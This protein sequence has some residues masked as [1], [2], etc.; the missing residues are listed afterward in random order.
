MKTA[1]PKRRAAADADASGASGRLPPIPAHGP[2]FRLERR[3]LGFSDVI[4]LSGVYRLI[5]WGRRVSRLFV[6]TAVRGWNRRASNRRRTATCPAIPGPDVAGGPLI[7]VLIPVFKPPERW[8]RA[9]LDSL[10]DQSYPNWEA[11]LVDDD[12]PDPWVRAVLEEYRARDVRFRIDYRRENGGI[13]RAT[14]Q[15][16]AMA[17][18]PFVALLDQDDS[19]TPDALRE[20]AHVIVATPDVDLVYSDEDKMAADGRLYDATYKPGWSPELLLGTMYVGHLSCYRTAAVVEVGGFRPAFDGAQDYDL[21]LRVTALGGK[22]HHI[23]KVLYHWTALAGSTAR[24]LSSKFYAIARQKVALEEHLGRTAATPGRV[25]PCRSAGY[26]RVVF[27]PPNPAPKVSIV[28]P[29]AGRTAWVAGRR[30]NLLVNC[31]DSVRK[32]N[33]YP[34]LEFVVIHNND[35]DKPTLSALQDVPDL[36]LVAYSYEVF[37]F[38][39]KLNVGVA[40][41]VGDYVLLMN[42]DVQVI[43][44]AFI[45]DLLGLSA[46]PGVGAVGPKLLFADGNIQH[47]GIT[48]SHGAPVHTLIGEPRA[49]VGPQHIASLTHNAVAATGAC[50]MVRRDLYLAVGG[51]NE[52]LPSNYNDVDFCLK[53]RD[54][55]LRIAIDPSIELYHFESLSKS[56][57]F[58]WELQLFVHRRG[59]LRDPY[60]NPNFRHSVFYRAGDEAQPVSVTTQIL[61]RIDVHRHRAVPETLR[62]S[63]ILGVYMAPIRL[64]D[65]LADTIIRQFYPHFEWLIVSDGDGRPELQAWLT[66]MER[67]DCR[68]KVISRP[69]NGGIMASYRTAFLAATGDYVVPVDQ[70][71]FLPL[72]ALEECAAFLEATGRPAAAYSDE[73]K[74]DMRSRQ[75]WPFHKP[76]LDTLL[77]TNM[78]YTAHLCAIRRDAALAHGLYQDHEATWCHDWDSF[79]RLL[80]AGERIE[81]LPELLYAWRINP[82]STAS[83]ATSGKPEAHRSHRHVLDQHLRLSGLADRLTVE[84]NPLYGHPG[85]WRLRPTGARLPPVRL[86]VMPSDDRNATLSRYAGLDLE[87]YAGGATLTL[88]DGPFASAMAAALVG[89]SPDTLIGVVDLDAEPLSPDWL[90]EMAGLIAPF[91]EAAAV[92]GRFSSRD[93]KILWRGGY[94]GFAGHIGSPDTGRDVRHSGYHGI[95]FAQHKVDVVAATGWLAR[96]DVLVEVERASQ[97]LE[98]ADP[99]DWATALALT[100]SR[101]GRD[102]LY[103]PFAHWRTGRRPPMPSMP[104]AAL[105]AALGIDWPNRSRYYAGRLSVSPAEAWQPTA[106]RLH[107]FD[108]AN[109]TF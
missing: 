52:E 46:Q 105:L 36:R 77:L 31:I 59:L 27:A 1:I 74:S 58:P 15:A 79:T 23:P 42:D 108:R 30:V 44:P 82:G 68:I 29:T 80:R 65:E 94:F 51:F 56:G 66:A 17:T 104:S 21:A 103:T 16:L 18:G 88:V 26:W 70:D 96:A 99:A 11:C 86:L 33:P 92:G 64:L 6:R 40:A 34:N 98:L 90:V 4:E 63:I 9:C 43:S 20:V 78:C 95:G 41:A 55:G 109:A 106:K 93:G 76:A 47:V 53:L 50:L 28:I 102:I 32:A 22:V 14:N 8:L 61:Q 38:S 49:T 60:L 67:R 89:A 75:F 37:N 2:L 5:E 7:S 85:L 101:M 12:S 69:D 3:P 87:A 71:D 97:G 25:E 39:E 91:P 19:L 84:E 13:S 72:D 57:T 100:A 35:L 54:R 45:A 48:L 24:T 107:E 10:L 62:F 81:H 73:F 83:L